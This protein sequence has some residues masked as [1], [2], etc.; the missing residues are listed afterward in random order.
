M[1]MSI[2]LHVNRQKRSI[3]SY[4]EKNYLYPQNLETSH[5]HLSMFADT[6]L[7]IQMQMK[8][9]LKLRSLGK[10]LVKIIPI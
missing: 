1:K 2:L 10:W 9:L 4:A 5:K 7:T 8:Q 6:I 3:K